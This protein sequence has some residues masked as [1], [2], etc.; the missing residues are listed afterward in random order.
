MYLKCPA[1]QV[2]ATPPSFTSTREVFLEHLS[3]SSFYDPHTAT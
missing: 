1:K 2:V 3:T